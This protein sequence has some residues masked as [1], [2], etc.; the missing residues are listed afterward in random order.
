[1]KNK[2][3]KA[4]ILAAGFGT[5]LKPLTDTT[6]KPL[7]EFKNKTLIDYAINF[8]ISLDIKEVVINLHYK[9][10]YIVEHLSQRTDIKIV[11]S[12]EKKILGTGGGVVNV[13]DKFHD[14]FLLLNSDII[15][16]EKMCQFF[17][18]FINEW[19][20]NAMDAFLLLSQK[21]K[22]S[23][24]YGEGDF[25]L[26]QAGQIIGE[27]S[28]GSKKDFVFAGAQLLNPKVL[29]NYSSAFFPMNNIWK[30]AISNKRLYGKI[31]NQEIKHLGSIDALKDIK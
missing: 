18:T 23:G 27:K 8:L 9:S 25:N 6:P 13:R 24:Y 31:A 21:D 29:D 14:V 30:D 20:N 2:I 28:G 4:M 15:W 26:N 12:H 5:R 11:F 17:L 7:I 22:I 10:E 19:D 3:S 1:M 16:E